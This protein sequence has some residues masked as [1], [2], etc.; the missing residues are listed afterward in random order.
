MNKFLNVYLYDVFVGKL[1][2]QQG[3]LSFS[4]D[5]C[6]LPLPQAKAISISMPL[7]NIS[8]EHH[9][10]SAYFSGLLPDEGVRFRL[11]KYLH[12]SEKIYL[13]CFRSY[14]LTTPENF[15]FKWSFPWANTSINEEIISLNNSRRNL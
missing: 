15:G 9:I 2:Y 11:A 10:V 13:V 5:D 6:Y 1:C 12:L 8:F 4:Y 3:K 7:S 14:A